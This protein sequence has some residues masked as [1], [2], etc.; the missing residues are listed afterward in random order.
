MQTW[1]ILEQKLLMYIGILLKINVHV[2]SILNF[3]DNTKYAIEWKW[4]K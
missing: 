1:N 4:L 2:Q 3:V